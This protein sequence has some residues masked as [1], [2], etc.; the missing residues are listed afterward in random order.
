MSFRETINLYS[1]LFC[2]AGVYS[3]VEECVCKVFT[4]FWQAGCSTRRPRNFFWN[5][6]SR[7]CVV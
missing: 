1:N 2:P 4:P 3:F 6:I 7:Y 5:I